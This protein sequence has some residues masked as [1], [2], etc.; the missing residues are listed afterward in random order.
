MANAYVFPGG[1]VDPAD[2][3]GGAELATRRCAVRELEEEASLRVADAGELVYF[4]RW[5]TPSLEPKRFDADFFLWALPPDQTPEVDAKEVFDLRWYTPAAALAEYEAGQLNLPP[6]TA[7]TLEDLQAELDQLSPGPSLLARLLQACR[8]RRPHVLLPRL[9]ASPE[10]G[11]EIVLP[12]DP[13]FATLPGE[14]DAAEEIA[15]GAARV[16]RR[17]SRCALVPPGAWR[18]TRLSQ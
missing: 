3:E 17:I 8:A 11:I 1:R 16:T 15:A 7:C 12:W 13:D 2:A 18:V 6:P 5:V 10:S 4:A 14:G 9:Q